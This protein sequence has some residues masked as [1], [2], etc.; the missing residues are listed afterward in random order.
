MVIHTDKENCSE[1]YTEILD[2]FSRVT[3]VLFRSDDNLKKLEKK[4]GCVLVGPYALV[5]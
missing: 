1:F 5:W 4:G 2:K 3:R